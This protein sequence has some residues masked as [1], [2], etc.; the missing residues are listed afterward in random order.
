MRV[1][2]AVPATLVRR[3]T[4]DDLAAYRALHRLGLEEAPIAFVE[5][6]DEDATRPDGAIAPILERGEAWGVFVD[7]RLAGKMT[8]DTMGYATLAHTRWVHSFYVHPDARGAGAAS[9]MLRGA[10][11]DARA[12]GASRFMLCVNP[13]N[14]PAWRLYEKLGFRE[15]GR[16]PGGI[17]MMGRVMDDVLMVLETA[18]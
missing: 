7:G 9:A 2:P 1:R 12:A 16:I 17:R 6:P 14:A 5:S 10:I 13:E 3:L 4:V 15:T 11:D 18:P 8:I